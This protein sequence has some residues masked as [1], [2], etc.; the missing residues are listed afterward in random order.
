MYSIVDNIHTNLRDED[1]EL[2]QVAESIR[3]ASE[4]ANDFVEPFSS[5]H[6]VL[7]EVGG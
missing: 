2:V 3:V 7:K 6:R 1:S 5:S 4:L